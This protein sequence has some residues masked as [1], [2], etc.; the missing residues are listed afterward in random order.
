ML[1]RNTD[2]LDEGYND[3]I[4]SNFVWML[5]CWF[6]IVPFRPCGEDTLEDQGQRRERRGDEWRQHD[7]QPSVVVVINIV[8]IQV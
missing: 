8:V 3:I 1:V 2:N 5:F 4:I 7:D 6:A